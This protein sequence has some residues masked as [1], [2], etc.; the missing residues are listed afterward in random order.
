[1][2]WIDDYGRVLRTPV[3]DVPVTVEIG[4]L[5]DLLFYTIDWFPDVLCR[6]A[7]LADVTA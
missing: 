5:V 6:F 3:Q 4:W 2:G 7:M 1:M